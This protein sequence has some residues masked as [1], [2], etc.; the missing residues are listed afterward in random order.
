[1]KDSRL[2]TMGLVAIIFCLAIKWS[3][4][5][6]LDVHR[7]IWLILVP[8]YARGGMLFGIWLLDYGRPTG[9]TGLE[10]FKNKLEISAFWGMLIP[11]ALSVGLG[12]KAMWLNIGFGVMTTAIIWYYKR[13]LGCITGDMLGAIT[14]STE[15]GLFLLASIG[16]KI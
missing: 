5:A 12:W 14:E 8:A 16:G 11:V 15:A 1:M 6:S 3:G 13:R 2:G 7:S 4:I 9:G 10:F